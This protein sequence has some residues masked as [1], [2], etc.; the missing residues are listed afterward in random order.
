MA[1]NYCYGMIFC[2]IS[3]LYKWAKCNQHELDWSFTCYLKK[4]I[5]KP[6]THKAW[7]TLRALTLTG[8]VHI[9]FS[10]VE[11]FRNDQWFNFSCR[12]KPH[13]KQMVCVLS[14]VYRSDFWR[15]SHKVSEVHHLCS[16]SSLLG[17]KNSAPISHGP[18]QRCS[19]K[20]IPKVFPG[21]P[22]E[23]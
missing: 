12:M 18:L 13:L 19:R 1:W 9:R 11:S 20:L 14:C 8:Y 21:L 2:E 16:F 5:T 23:K 22:F 17:I 10:C 6:E 4:K 3:G 7:V 15:E